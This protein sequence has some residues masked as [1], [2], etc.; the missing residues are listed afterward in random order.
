MTS[1]GRLRADR[2]LT[3][4]GRS[5]HLLPSDHPAIKEQRT[6]YPGMVRTAG[7][8]G[9]WALKSGMYNRKVGRVVQVGKWT[10]L[11]IYTLTLPERATCPQTCEHLRSCY[12]NHMDFAPRMR[13]GPE[14]ESRLAAEVEVLDV[15]HVHGFVVRLHVLGDFYSPAYVELWAALLRQYSTLRVFGYTRRHDKDDPITAAL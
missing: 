7:E 8:G 15:Q 4:K 6:L 9:L 10:G 1:R 12:G 13:P 5:A 3:I 11:P 2:P 14:L